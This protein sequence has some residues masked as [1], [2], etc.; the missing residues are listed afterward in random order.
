MRAPAGLPHLPALF[1]ATAT[2]A[3]LAPLAGA[4]N[5]TD[6]RQAI[7]ADLPRYD[8]AAYEKAQAEKAARAAPKNA[9][10]EL[11][12]EKPAPSSSSVAVSEGILALPKVTVHPGTEPPKPLP[13]LDTFKPVHDTPGEDFESQGARDARLVRNHLTPFQ[14]ALYRLFHVSPVAAARQA[15]AE[16]EKARQMNEL[17]AGI[18]IQEALGRDPAEIRK[19]RAEY[20]KL[21]YSGP[22]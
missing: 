6:P 5:P 9:P 16:Q 14:Q 10:A 15:E 8:P 13:R 11:P 4:D 1:S 22:K 20:T 12:A 3:L 7:Q 2:L 17:A 18:E 21:Y 19:L